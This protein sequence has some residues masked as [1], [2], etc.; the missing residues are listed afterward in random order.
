MIPSPE[1]DF[2]VAQIELRQALVA[3]DQCQHKLASVKEQ[4]VRDYLQTKYPESEITVS[5]RTHA[6]NDLSRLMGNTLYLTYGNGRS[7]TGTL[8]TEVNDYLAKLKEEG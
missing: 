5:C 4:V 6:S 3:A 7:V 8:L 1:R 2:I